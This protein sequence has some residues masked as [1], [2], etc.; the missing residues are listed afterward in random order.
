MVEVKK[1][2]SLKLGPNWDHE[3]LFKE[4]I[5]QNKELDNWNLRRESI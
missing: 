5:P 1:K 3:C 2:T 4:Q